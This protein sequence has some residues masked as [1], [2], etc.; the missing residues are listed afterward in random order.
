MREIYLTQNAEKYMAN[1]PVNPLVIA[2]GLS[3]GA[4]G[5]KTF[6]RFLDETLFDGATFGDLRKR[7]NVITWINATDLANQTTF[8][9]TP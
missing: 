2:R 1:S 3:G 6:G 5:R 7:S 9:F 8:L 4:N